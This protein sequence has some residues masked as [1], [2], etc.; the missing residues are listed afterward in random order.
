MTTAAAAAAAATHG[1]EQLDEESAPK[2]QVGTGEQTRTNSFF[3]ITNYFSAAFLCYALRMHAL[4]QALLHR[5]HVRPP[6][7]ALLCS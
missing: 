6:L 1:M 2:M 3:C 5:S 4:L 7:P